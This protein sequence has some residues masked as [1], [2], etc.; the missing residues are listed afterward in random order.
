MPTKPEDDLLIVHV[1]PGDA[2]LHLKQDG[3][4][5]YLPTLRRDRVLSEAVVLGTALALA[6]ANEEWRKKI[7]DK[8]RRKIVLKLNQPTNKD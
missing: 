3:T 6:L 2:V 4:V 5:D 1:E 8:A 7:M